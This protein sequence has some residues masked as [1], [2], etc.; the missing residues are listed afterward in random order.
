MDYKTE[1][2]LLNGELAKTKYNNRWSLVM[3]ILSLLLIPLGFYYTGQAYIQIIASIV[4][5]GCCIWN[6]YNQ[7]KIFKEIE[8]LKKTKHSQ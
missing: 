7:R 3:L 5:A 6:L 2:D 8:E 4:I 1:E